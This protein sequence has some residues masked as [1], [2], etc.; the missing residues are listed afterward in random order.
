[1][2]VEKIDLNPEMKWTFSAYVIAGDFIYT[3]HIAALV[4]DE[5]NKLMNVAGQTD[6]CFRNLKRVLETADATLDDVVK[7]TVYLKNLKD[8]HEMREVY[9]RQFTGGYPARMT[10]T[11]EFIEPDCLVMIEAVAY[12]PR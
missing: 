7:T 5:G 2:A 6:Q 12:K 8:F 3:S 9:R 10:A 4:D 1:M 11:T